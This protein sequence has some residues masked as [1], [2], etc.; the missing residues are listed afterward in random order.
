MGCGKIPHFTSRCFGEVM[1]HSNENRVVEA[2]SYGPQPELS[3]SETAGKDI[4]SCE[5]LEHRTATQRKKLETVLGKYQDIFRGRGNLP[6]TT[7]ID[8]AIQLE[9]VKLI[10][11]TAYHRFA[12][13]NANVIEEIEQAKL[14]ELWKKVYKNSHDS[15][16]KQFKQH[17]KRA[18]PTTYHVG[19]WESYLSYFHRS[20]VRPRGGPRK[21]SVIQEFDKRWKK[22]GLHT[23]EPTLS[24]HR[25]VCK[26]VKREKGKSTRAVKRSRARLARWS[27]SV[28]EFDTQL[29]E[30]W[31]EKI[32]LN[33]H[34][35]I[36]SAVI[37]SPY[38]V[39]V[40]QLLRSK[41]L[42]IRTL[43]PEQYDIVAS[44]SYGPRTTDHGPTDTE[45][46]VNNT[47]F[48]F[49]AKEHLSL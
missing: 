31:T 30:G 19:D 48:A 24:T 29:K 22:S 6:L 4:V 33:A 36:Y 45:S 27:T 18:L 10:A 23:L 35:H 34:A 12:E 26:N 8:H 1:H 28:Q 32:N 5:K 17:D 13:K 43:W 25:A 9:K 15:F 20:K 47:R 2:T 11:Q 7:S 21:T 16:V 44:I 37:G 3:H 38:K 40:G 49:N 39:K 42:R 46:V 41:D 14:Q